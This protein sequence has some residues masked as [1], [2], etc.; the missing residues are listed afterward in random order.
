MGG[1]LALIGGAFMVL[2][3]FPPMAGM[4]DTPV[5]TGL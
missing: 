4:M 5:L 3:G 2:M 1:P